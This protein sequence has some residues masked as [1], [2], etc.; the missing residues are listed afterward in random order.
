MSKCAYDRDQD[1]AQQAED[2][3]L[4]MGSAVGVVYQMIHGALRL[5]AC[6][7]RFMTIR[8]LSSLKLCSVCK[9]LLAADQ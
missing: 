3:D 7:G 2:D 1:R 9:C 4:Q 6:L 8:P 5:F